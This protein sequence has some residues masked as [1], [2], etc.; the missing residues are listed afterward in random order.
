VTPDNATLIAVDCGCKTDD[1]L[2]ALRAELR[3]IG[4]DLADIRTRNQRAGE[5][6][7]VR[8]RVG[9]DRSGAGRHP[10]EGRMRAALCDNEVMPYEGIPS[11]GSQLRDAA[12][13]WISSES[14][15]ASCRGLTTKFAAARWRRIWT[16]RTSP[17]LVRSTTTARSS[18]RSRV[19]C[20]RS[21]STI[22]RACFWT[23]LTF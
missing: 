7:V 21:S 19:R 23:A 10:P 3:D 11:D 22:P 20:C 2:D 16:R 12:C 18:T 4:A 17:G 15:S 9:H 13:C 8:V 5:A 14:I 1:V 6:I